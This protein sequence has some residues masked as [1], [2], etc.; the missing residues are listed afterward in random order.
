MIIISSSNSSNMFA[1]VVHLLPLPVGDIP[2][3][4]S[5]GC[6]GPLLSKVFYSKLTDF[7]EFLGILSSRY[8]SFSRCMNFVSRYER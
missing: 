5:Q 1:R 3:S 4:I 7:P 6:L 8:S 2:Y